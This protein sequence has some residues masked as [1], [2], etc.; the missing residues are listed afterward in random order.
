MAAKDKQFRELSDEEL[1][2][3]NGGN[4]KDAVTGSVSSVHSQHYYPGE[5]L[6]VEED[7]KIKEIKGVDVEI[8]VS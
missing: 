4:R 2:L 3:V 1:K 5:I 7:L 8:V 6:P